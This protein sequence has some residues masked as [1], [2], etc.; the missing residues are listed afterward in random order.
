M[1]AEQRKGTDGA[2]REG[3]E[4]RDHDRGSGAK[5]V[6][7]RGVRARRAYLPRARCNSGLCGMSYVGSRKYP[8]CCARPSWRKWRA[9][10]PRPLPRICLRDHV[11]QSG[12]KGRSKL[13]RAWRPGAPGLPRACPWRHAV[14]QQGRIFTPDPPKRAFLLSL[15]VADPPLLAGRMRIRLCCTDTVPEPPAWP[16]CCG[17]AGTAGTL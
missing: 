8:L 13:G 12:R 14:A 3:R 1:K 2:E 9:E 5:V 4:A 15:Y 6:A 10:L 16:S 17:R 7:D 11:V